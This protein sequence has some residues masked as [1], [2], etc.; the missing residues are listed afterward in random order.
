MHEVRISKSSI[1][2]EMRLQNDVRN[3]G[4]KL[5]G[6]SMEKALENVPSEIPVNEFKRE[7][8]KTRR[9]LPCLWQVVR[10][11]LRWSIHPEKVLRGAASL[12]H[13]FVLR[14]IEE[15][16]SN[17]QESK[18]MVMLS[19]ITPTES[20]IVVPMENRS[21]PSVP[22]IE[23]RSKSRVLPMKNRSL[24]STQKT[25]LIRDQ[26]RRKI[27]STRP[28]ITEQTSLSDAA[29]ELEANRKLIQ[30]NLNLTV[31]HK[32]PKPPRKKHDLTFDTRGLENLLK[33]V[34]LSPRFSRLKIELRCRVNWKFYRWVQN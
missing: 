20:Q 3:A 15:E 24:P 33:Q 29:V 1:F 13:L 19:C 26:F 14:T 34:E 4:V 10:E 11:I 8:Q 16:S 6:V 18:S 7:L 25:K 9:V 30:E 12:N 5:A 31:E 32:L 23:N 17:V 27:V 2:E 22:P 28:M 21:R